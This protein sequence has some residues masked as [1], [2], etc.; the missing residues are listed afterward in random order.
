MIANVDLD[1]GLE[2]RGDPEGFQEGK[3]RIDLMPTFNPGCDISQQECSA[4]HGP[5]NPPRNASD[6]KDEHGENVAPYVYPQ[7]VSLS[8]ERPP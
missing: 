4:P 1:S 7:V 8:P 6:R 2:V 3:S 5:S